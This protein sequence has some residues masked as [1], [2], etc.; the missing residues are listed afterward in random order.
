VAVLPRRFSSVAPHDG[1]F[2]P[3]VS[4]GRSRS[5]R[6]HLP[7]PLR[8]FGRFL[9]GVEIGPKFGFRH[10]TARLTINGVQ[11]PAVH[12]DVIHDG[13]RLMNPGLQRAP[14]L[15]MAASL[16]VLVETKP[17][18]MRRR[19]RPERFR[20]FGIRLLPAA[21]WLPVWS[22][23]GRS[24]TLPGSPLPSATRWPPEYLPLV[25]RESALQSRQANPD[26][27]PHTA[28][29]REKSGPVSCVSYDESPLAQL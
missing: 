23:F 14:H 3:A 22:G 8:R 16:R 19:S 17:A 18:R 4:H 21:P 24:P 7:S 12:L 6:L 29:H 20:S 15:D 9:V 13:Q 28:A 11:R 2:E 25:R 10:K 26:T 1:S 27:L 5:K